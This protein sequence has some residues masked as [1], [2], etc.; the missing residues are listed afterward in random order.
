MQV[1][2]ELWLVHPDSAACDAFSN[3]FDGLPNVR[4][5]QDSFE[6]LDRH[7][8]FVTAANSFGMMT[9]GIDAVVVEY[10]GES[11]MEAVQHEIMDTFLGEQ[12]VG[13]AFVVPTDNNRIPFLCHAPTMRVPASID[14]SA[15]VY[16]ATWAALVAIHQHN[17]REE[18][19]IHT[20]AFPAFGTGF[21]GMSFSEAARQMAAAYQHY[22]NPPHRLD[23]DWVIERHK[24]LS[25]D[26][27]QR[28]LR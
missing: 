19:T 1:P 25:Y 11:L 8:C 13:T 26:G 18:S 6:N 9:A 21:G 4:I 7:D 5:I 22:L 27:D 10:F 16:N 28:V 2:L 20:V 12:P 15:N 23:W 14:G 3:R 17:V 24:R